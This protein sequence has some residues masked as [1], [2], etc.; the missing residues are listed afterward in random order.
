MLERLAAFADASGDAAGPKP[1]KP[2]IDV[3]LPFSE[4]SARKAFDT[5]RGRRTAGKIVMVMS[6]TEEGSV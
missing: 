6:G 4:E 3:Q 5:L 2:K 1:L